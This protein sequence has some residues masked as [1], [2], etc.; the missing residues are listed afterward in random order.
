M[1]IENQLP[2][3]WIKDTSGG[4]SE[5]AESEVED[6]DSQVVVIGLLAS[7]TMLLHL[8]IFIII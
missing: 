8:F 4:V 2:F 1:T 5:E 3:F 7:S 6:L